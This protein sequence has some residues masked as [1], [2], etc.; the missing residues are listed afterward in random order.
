MALSFL[1]DLL[2]QLGL[3][4]AIL[5]QFA[6]ALGDALFDDLNTGP[7]EQVLSTAFGSAGVLGSPPPPPPF[8]P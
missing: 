1:L 8:S 3:D 5:A 7:A 4:D 2:E 6:D